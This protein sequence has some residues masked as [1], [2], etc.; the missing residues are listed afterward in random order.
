MSILEEYA[1]NLTELVNKDPQRYITIG[2]DR[3]IEKIIE[4]LSRKN[5][6]NPLIIAEAGVGKTNLVEGLAKCLVQNQVPIRLRNKQIY[7]LELSSLKQSGKDFI[8][9]FRKIISEVK[10]SG[11]ILFIDE[12][13]TIVGT[14]S[15]NG[16]ALDVSN[17]LKPALARGEITLIGA[18]TI[19]EYHQYLESD[20]ALERRFEIVQVN[21]P[22]VN[23]SY[24]IIRGL[25]TN[26]E[27]FHHLKIEEDVL[28]KAVD[29]AIRYIPERYLPDKAFDLLDEACS[30]AN[31][32]K[33]DKVTKVTLAKVIERNYRIPID[34]IMKEPLTRL[35]E[36]ERRLK[37][38]IK[39]Q[40]G[41]VKAIIDALTLYFSGLQDRSKPISSFLF[42][43]MPG[44]GKTET[45][46]Q[47]AK[48]MFD[49]ED[50]MIRLDMSEFKDQDAIK[51]LIGNNDRGGILTES[52]KHHP[53]SIILL[54]EIE[55][56]SHEVQD[57]FLQ[58]LQDGILHDNY[59][60][61]ISF[62]NTIIIMT[63]NLAQTV[64][65]DQTLFNNVKN[66]A[67]RQLQFNAV[68][69]KALK[70]EFRPEFVNR[71]EHKIIFNMLDEETV[72]EIAAGYLTRFK[73]E[74]KAKGIELEY[75]SDVV[76]YLATVG[77]DIQNGARPIQYMLNSRIKAAFAR[78][79]LKNNSKNVRINHLK[80]NV[81]GRWP[82]MYEGHKDRYGDLKIIFEG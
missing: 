45:A 48:S 62:K 31:V 22:S 58:I 12:I 64:V 37:R 32:H 72:K 36:I 70:N 61:P 14:G 52:V 2:R 38:N 10:Q 43:G 55:K 24:E 39:G 18:T 8:G 75:T 80:V 11:S 76:K 79:L 3:D 50:A 82:G 67:Q 5:K 41:A 53:Y 46:K 57:L 73:K 47:L 35:I 17:V 29:Y 9:L 19:K 49:S 74:V 56:G 59:G 15:E 81:S 51:R 77:F 6:S 20:E 16:N 21:E 27:S 26:Y 7:S 34:S 4:T 66:S 42:L 54:D 40:P 1:T 71:I 78:V 65:K 30:Y 69:E 60:R 68:V 33:E 23:Q 28:Y 25:K 13:H 63:T 44:T